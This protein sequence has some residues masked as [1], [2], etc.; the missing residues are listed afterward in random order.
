MIRPVELLREYPVKLS[1]GYQSTTTKVWEII[2]ASITG[3]LQKIKQLVEECPALIYAQYNYAPPIHFAVREG[4]TDLVKY[5]LA[6]G[7]HDP[8][9]KIYPFHESLQVLAEDRAL[10]EI[11][12]LLDDYCVNQSGRKYYKGD[13]GEILYNRSE[14]EKEFERVVDKED[15]KRTK[16]ILDKNPDFALDPTYFWSEGILLFAVKEANYKMIDLLMS[17]GATV[18]D[19]L[20]WTQFYYF[21]R[22]DGA[23]YIMEKGMNP[24]TMS[25]HHVTILHDM[26]Q[27]GNIEKAE[28]LIK[29]GAAINP[30]DEQYQSTPL[31]MAVRW[32]QV[33]MVEYLLK[34]GADVHQSGASWSTPLSWAIKK[35]H[36]DIEAM[37]RRAGAVR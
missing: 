35:N 14:L 9:Y 6:N 23:K 8:E 4:H 32:G 13:N 37:L 24:D 11:V 31:G 12:R 3:D 21:E 27:K 16:E 29:H 19:I 22:Y 20:K 5:L 2:S 15:L 28:L 1:D 7:A 34:N 36:S 26:A 18:P 10:N 30:V 33:E 17:Y 25:C